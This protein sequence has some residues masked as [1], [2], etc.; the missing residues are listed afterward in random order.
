M[1]FILNILVDIFASMQE[2]IVP[3]ALTAIISIIVI[4]ILTP[5]CF[6]QWVN[7]K[8]FRWMGA[9][10]NL[11]GVQVIRLTC[12]WIKLVLLIIYLC[13]FEELSI[14]KYIIFLIPGIIYVFDFRHPGRIPG[15]LFWLIIETIGL[16]TANIVCGYIHDM[17]PG[18]VFTIIYIA[19]SIF[20][21]LFGVY[22]FITELGDIS[23][24]RKTPIG[25]EDGR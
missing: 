6:K 3:L 11:D 20:L 1:D 14:P 7:R 10:F 17:R 16:I 15:R 2:L 23:E 4:V 13:M 8:S 9:F 19:I 22:L 18:P 12:A 24:S 25:A 21:G 5:L